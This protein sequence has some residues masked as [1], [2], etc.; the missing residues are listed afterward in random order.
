MGSFGN[1]KDK[2]LKEIVSSPE[3]KKAHRNMFF[4]NCPGCSCGYPKNLR[5]YLPY[6]IKEAEY[7]IFPFTR[8]RVWR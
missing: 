2:P 6:L 4:K 7:R 1:L 3:Y 8:S 5:Y